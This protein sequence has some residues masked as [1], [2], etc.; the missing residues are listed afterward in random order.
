MGTSYKELWYYITL[1]VIFI[2]IVDIGIKV[3]RIAKDVI[4]L[5]HRVEVISDKQEGTINS[6][7]NN[8]SF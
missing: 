6:L 2:L 3:T 8:I 1:A 5:K 4:H 7:C